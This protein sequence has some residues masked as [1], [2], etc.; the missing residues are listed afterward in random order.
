M[1]AR[2]LFYVVLLTCASQVAA[3]ASNSQETPLIPTLSWSDIKA[4][5]PPNREPGDWNLPKLKGIP[6][7]P[8]LL[9]QCKSDLA[10]TLALDPK[11]L[12]V[13][14]FVPPGKIVL[15]SL[16]KDPENRIIYFV[17]EY[18]SELPGMFVV[19]YYDPEQERFILKSRRM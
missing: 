12:A 3:S 10:R 1:C 8:E 11:S 15:C 13:G 19:Y 2:L 14:P 4:L 7:E 6:H 9:A 18:E 16:N 5:Y 17:L